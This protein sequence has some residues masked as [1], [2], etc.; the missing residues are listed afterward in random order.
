M[1]AVPCVE[2]GLAFPVRYA[3][4]LV[5]RGLRLYGYARR[6]GSGGCYA[7]CTCHCARRSPPGA[8]REYE[9]GETQ[10]WKSRPGSRWCV[11]ACR[12]FS[13]RL[14]CGDTMSPATDGYFL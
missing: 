11:A 2:Y 7:E 10:A 14:P 5:E 4:R 1:V 8:G 9:N 12:S 3:S 13:R 6:G